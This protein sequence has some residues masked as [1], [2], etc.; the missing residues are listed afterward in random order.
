MPDELVLSR[1]DGPVAIIQVN[2]ERKLNAMNRVVLATVIARLDEAAADPA[3]HA[4]VITG[5]GRAFIAGADIGEYWKQGLGAFTE[6]QQ[7]G[8]QLLERIERHSKPVIAAVNGF[9]LGG[10]FEI[11]LA[12]D[13]IVAGE[14]AVFGLPEPGLGLVPGGGG[15][16]RLTRAVGRYRAKEVLLC[17]RRLTARE[18][19]S[20]GLVAAVAPPGEE[21]RAALRLAGQIARLAP[22]AVRATKRL[23]NEGED[24]AL[25]TALSYE[26]QT[27]LALYAT[28]DGQEGINAFMEK[29]PAVFTGA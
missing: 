17:G 11:A 6:Y 5:T 7:L 3:V 18:A 24:A 14:Q 28:A 22:L 23:I 29:R 10:G 1:R 16:Q 26:Q 4:A 13:L 20:W 8:R 15:T 27:L 21:M 9:A 2:R 25:A 19:Q 12:C